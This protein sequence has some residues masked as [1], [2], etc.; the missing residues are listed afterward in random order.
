MAARPDSGLSPDEAGPDAARDAC[1]MLPRLS[2]EGKQRPFD[3][4]E[5]QRGARL[6]VRAPKRGALSP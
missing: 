1:L 6:T 4:E 5:Q 3:I 2:A